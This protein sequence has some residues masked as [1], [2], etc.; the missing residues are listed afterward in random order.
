MFLNDLKKLRESMIF[1]ELNLD[2]NKFLR[3]TYGKTVNCF[4]VSG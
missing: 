2:L 4:L 1:G 3:I